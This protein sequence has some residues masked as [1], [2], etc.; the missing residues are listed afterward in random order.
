[1]ER[2]PILYQTIYRRYE[3][4]VAKLAA[5][6]EM[7]RKVTYVGQ[8]VIGDHGNKCGGIKPAYRRKII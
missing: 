7:P 6:L 2:I 5:R 8:Q 3:R 4:R 1:M